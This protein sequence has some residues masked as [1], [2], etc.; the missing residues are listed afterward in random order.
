MGFWIKVVKKEP[1]AKRVSTAYP[2]YPFTRF[3]H[4]LHYNF[5]RPH[6]HSKYK[7]PVE[8]GVIMNGDNMPAKWQ[9]MI[10]LGQKTI[11]QMQKTAS[12]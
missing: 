12:A 1:R 9:L 6:K 8:D 3:M 5:L 11:Q 4:R 7:P 10:F 2:F